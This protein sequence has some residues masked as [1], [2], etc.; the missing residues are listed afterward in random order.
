MHNRRQPLPQKLEIM[1]A[2][3]GIPAGEQI[4]LDKLDAA[5]AT[6]NYSM[7]TR[8]AFKAELGRLGLIEL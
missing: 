4:P 7:A 8:L 2:A 1:L 3:A 5:M 6:K